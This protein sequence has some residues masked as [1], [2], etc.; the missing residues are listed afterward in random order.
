MSG[1]H[2]AG[3]FAFVDDDREVRLGV[4]DAVENFFT[5]HTPMESFFDERPDWWPV[6]F[7]VVGL[8]PEVPV[9]V[10]E[11][12]W[13]VLEILS[14]AGEPIGAY[15]VGSTELVRVDRRPD[16]RLDVAVEG[17]VS[18]PVEAGV[19]PI[20]DRWRS[21][22]PD[23]PN[24]W[25]ELPAGRR[26]AW[27]DVAANYRQ[28]DPLRRGRHTRSGERPV[29]TLDGRHVTDL[30][31]FYCALGEAVNGPGG[32]FGN[33]PYALRDHLNGGG[34][35]SVPFTLA[36]RDFEVAERH[37]G[38]HLPVVLGVLAEAGVTVERPGAVVAPLREGPDA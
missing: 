9:Q 14:D 36:W 29:V 2:P 33:N 31:G 19:E 23:E 4:A 21:G 28:R 6:E 25:A 18:L 35:V 13:T 30:A 38:E 8:R 32:Y 37:L 15:L 17:L 26:E 12:G 27:L 24:T 3:R 34:G 5:G 7:T 10:G 16:G 20:W 11:L 22:P 1:T